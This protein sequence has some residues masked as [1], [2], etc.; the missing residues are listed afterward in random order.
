MPYILFYRLAQTYVG[1][2]MFVISFWGFSPKSL[3][4]LTFSVDSDTLYDVDSISGST[5]F[6]MT[7]SMIQF[8][9]YNV[10]K[11]NEVIIAEDE[12]D[13]H[14]MQIQLTYI[15]IFRK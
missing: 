12:G 11:V 14:R 6:H 2:Y 4:S 9:E 1:F 10:F 7:L 5:D 15:I 13:H 8:Y 3:D